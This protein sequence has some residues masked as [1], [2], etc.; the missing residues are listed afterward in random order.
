MMEYGQSSLL[1]SNMY[2]EN[3]ILCV[4]PARSGSKGLPGKNIMN[5]C[6]KPLIA[7]TVDHALASKYIDR[8][9]TSTDDREIA[10]IA[11]E[12]GSEV[13][14][15]RPIYLAGD[16]TGMIDV[17][18]HVVDWA[19]NVESYSFDIIMFLHVTTPLRDVEDIDKCIEILVDNDADNVFSVRVAHKNPYFNMV[20]PHGDTVGLVKEGSF[21]SRQTAPLV[22]DMNASIYVWWKGI[23]KDKRGL[24]LDKTMVY[25]MPKER[26]I[27]IDDICDFKFAELLMM[28]KLKKMSV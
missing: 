8:V 10:K 28:D 15:M 25:C 26:S 12:C 2:K 20:E 14:F 19:E 23:L 13:P 22:Y 27:D 18:L 7:Y 16:E 5:L 6:G 4:I 1:T 3:K 17:L 21:T 11:Q 24:F 9:I